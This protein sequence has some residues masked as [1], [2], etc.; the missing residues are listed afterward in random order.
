MNQGQVKVRVSHIVVR[1]RLRV[2]GQ[3]VQKTGGRMEVS[4]HRDRD[5]FGLIVLHDS[6]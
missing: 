6:I 1:F 3:A 5:T 4:P 2:F